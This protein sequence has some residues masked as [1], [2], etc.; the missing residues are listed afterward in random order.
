MD[1]W[2]LEKYKKVFKSFAKNLDRYDICLGLGE[3]EKFFW[4]FC[5]DYIELVKRRLY[6]PDV[7]GEK[8]CE[9]A[10]Y[11]C[12]YTLLGILKMFAPFMPH[13]T[14]EIYQD[15]YAEKENQVSIHVSGYLNLGEAKDENFV[16]FAKFADYFFYA[17]NLANF[18][19]AD[20]QKK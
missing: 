13:I 7:Y 3:A 1:K 20:I 17:E 2:I 9:S 14:E 4:D 6:N 5:D 11:A 8:E 10:K 12:Y 19:I 16:N 18:A 15:Y